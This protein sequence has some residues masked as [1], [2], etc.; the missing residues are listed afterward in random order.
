[1]LCS[2]LSSLVLGAP[3]VGAAGAK[4]GLM[5]AMTCSVGLVMMFAM[6]VSLHPG[7]SEQWTCYVLG[8]ILGGSGSGVLWTAQGAFFAS[9]SALVGA[10][11][12]I[13]NEQATSDLSGQFAAVLLT[14]E[15]ASRFL[16]SLLQ[17]T[18]L[19]WE[20][21][22]PL[23]SPGAIF[24]LFASVA[25]LTVVG[26]SLFV[27]AP[28]DAQNANGGKQAS[29]IQ[30]IAKVFDMWFS[31]EIWCLSFTNLTF[32]FC[33]GYMNGVVNGSFAK[34]SSAFGAARLGSLLATT[35]VV[36]AVA[37]PVCGF[38][39]QHAGKGL[40]ISIGA[41]SFAA[42][43]ASILLATPDERNGYWGAALISLY[44]LQGIARAV[45]ESTNKAVFA[46]FFPGDKSPPAFANC[47]MQSST[48]FFASFILQST[49]TTEQK[50]T[51]AWI[52]LALAASIFPGYL[53][54]SKLR[55]RASAGLS[56]SLLS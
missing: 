16:A 39:S 46:D 7:S 44:V 10:S 2:M 41:A 43:P 42:I 50:G 25:M 45:Y 40:T 19:H 23:M 35:S 3:V 1:M 15:I 11:E 32:G 34:L 55:G 4:S 24:L 17:G 9:T 31:P 51:L 13:S 29:V 33:A 20:L 49:L 14:F 53:V 56:Q 47:M 5:L 30:N 48:A 52:V 8:A 38:L 28:I 27:I 6:A 12:G 21:F 37:A 54:A 26:M 36:A 22:E 18:F